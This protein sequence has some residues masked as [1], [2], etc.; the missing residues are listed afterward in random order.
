MTQAR[1]HT[2]PAVPAPPR[3]PLPTPDRIAV[4]RALQLGDMLCSVPALRALRQSWPRA[5]VTVIGLGEGGEFRRRFGHYIDDWMRFPGLRIFPE[6]CA[7]ESALP[8]F[9]ERARARRFDIALQM[10]GS[11]L[12]S[13]RVVAQL[14]ARRWAGFV[15]PGEDPAPCRVPWPDEQP[16]PLRYLT[17]LNA[18]LGLTA[19]D[20]ALEF[21]LTPVDHAE[22]AALLR[23]AGLQS[24]RTVLVHPGAR[25]ASRRWPVERFGAVA[26]A[27]AAQGWQVAVTGTPEEAAIV[28]AAVAASGGVARDLCGR[29]SLGGLAAL[30]SRCRMV[31][32]N[33]TGMSHVC[34]AVGTRS[35]VVASGSD[36]RR[37]A[38][39]DP[40]LHPVLWTDVPCRPCSYESCPIG[41]PCALGVTVDQ[42]LAQAGRHLQREAA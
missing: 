9:Y 11:G 7:D 16:E 1:L 26:A 41:H 5:H 40:A 22:A 29:T 3:P 31:V 20:A 34:A 37:W 19:H 21:P 8:A 4:F 24:A 30:V 23:E 25:L 32:C 13:N 6:Q 12:Q 33:D 17:L 14:G 38:P 36:V 35:V 18:G 27:L 10:H 15:P 39:L 42:V 2:R 28:A